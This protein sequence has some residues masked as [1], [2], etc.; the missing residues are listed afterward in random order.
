MKEERNVDSMQAGETGKSQ[1]RDSHTCRAVNRTQRA[2]RLWGMGKEIRE[3]TPIVQALCAI[4]SSSTRVKAE[5]M[6]NNVAVSPWALA[7]ASQSRRNSRDV[8]RS[9]S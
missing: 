9:R 2:V 1:S 8:P 6:R 4:R 7:R 3:R 5:A